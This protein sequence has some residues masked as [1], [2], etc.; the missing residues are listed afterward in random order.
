MTSATQ[1][2]MRY[3]LPPCTPYVRLSSPIQFQQPLQL[4]KGSLPSLIFPPKCLVQVCSATSAVSV[5]GLGGVS[6]R[7]VSDLG[8]GQRLRASLKPLA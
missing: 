4:P 2:S 3:R 1:V 5:S 6:G 7:S 8:S